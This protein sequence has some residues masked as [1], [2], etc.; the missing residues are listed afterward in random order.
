MD[1][2]KRTIMWFRFTNG[3]RAKNGPGSFTDYEIYH[4]LRTKVADDKL[5]LAL[6]GLKQIPDVKNLAE[7]VQKYQFKFWVSEN[8]TPTS[9][10]K[11]LGIPH[12]PSLVTE[13]GPK[14]AILSQ[15]YVLFAKEKKLTRSTTMR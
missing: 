12:N 15:F 7:S 14:D 13:R 5:A 10:A 11:L 1:T 9:I 8:Q 2:N 3:Y 6:E 4:L